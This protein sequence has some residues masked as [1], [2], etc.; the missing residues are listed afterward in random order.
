M[1]K[2]HP[3][4]SRFEVPSTLG[5]ASALLLEPGR[6]LP[7][8]FRMSAESGCPVDPIPVLRATRAH[9]FG[10]PTDR[11]VAVSPQFAAG[12]RF[13][14][15]LTFAWVPVLLAD[16]PR[17]FVRMTAPCPATPVGL[18]HSIPA[19]EGLFGGHRRLVVAPSPDDRVEA[20]DEPRLRGRSPLPHFRMQLTEMVALSCFRGF[21]EGGAAQGDALAGFPGFRVAH[22]VLPDVESEEIEPCGA[23]TRV[24][25][26]PD[27]RFTGFH[28]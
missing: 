16:P 6:P 4:L 23:F 14:R 15:P 2:F 26:R 3:V 25:R 24:E 20:V 21:A 17:R 19:D 1:V 28:S 13:A 12:G 9:D 22:R 27:P 7:R 18:E 10:I 8:R 11:R 5:A